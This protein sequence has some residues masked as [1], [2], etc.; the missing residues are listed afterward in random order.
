[1]GRFFNK[2]GK[3]GKVLDKA[4]DV[5][6][7][8]QAGKMAKKAGPEALK[9]VDRVTK[10]STNNK[11]PGIVTKLLSNADDIDNFDEIAKLA[12]KA[13][14][15]VKKG[16]TAKT[17]AK[18]IS[19]D[20]D[21]VN[22]LSRMSSTAA[23][24]I[25]KA[26][27][28]GINTAITKGIEV[29]P[30]KV[31]NALKYGAMGNQV[32]QGGVSAKSIYDNVQEHGLKDG[33]RYAQLSDIRKVGQLGALGYSSY[34]NNM[35]RKAYLQNSTEVGATP[36]Q[37]SIKVGDKT[38]KTTGKVD[39]SKGFWGKIKDGAKGTTAKGKVAVRSE[40]QTKLKEEI[41]KVLD[42][43]E[44]DK[45]DE[46]VK[47]LTKNKGKIENI[48]TAGTAG[49]RIVNEN[50]TDYTYKGLKRHKRAKRVEAYQTGNYSTS[51]MNR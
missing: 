16:D 41:K 28:R 11:L 44:A 8:A 5:K 51:F 24:S 38:Y 36:E 1:M 22:K 42:P 13:G 35:N 9:A 27:G 23:G 32:I 49:T 26:T 45:I 20:L 3:A 12:T 37:Y 15:T 4:D 18:V 31:G 48:Y 14:Y 17:L 10:L 2:A 46:I 6:G 43:S 39:T 50:P 47:A 34:Q 40:N 19:S 33:L 29:L 30:G 25:A 7:L 21:A